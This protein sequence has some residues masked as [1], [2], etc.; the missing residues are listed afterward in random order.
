[1][2]EFKLGPNGELPKGFRFLSL[3]EVRSMGYRQWLAANG[4]DHPEPDDPPQEWVAWYLDAPFGS[5][6]F[7]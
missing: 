7:T 2:N 5:I 1:M 6:D 4:Q 3:E